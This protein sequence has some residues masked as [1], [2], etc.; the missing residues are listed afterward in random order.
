[1][2]NWIVAFFK[3]SDNIVLN[4]QSLDGFLLLRYLKVSVVL[5]GFGVLITWPILMPVNVTGG[6][7]QSQL[8]SLSF[9]NIAN[10]KDRYYAHVLV[11]WIFFALVF[12][13]VMR[14]S[15]YY[16][17]IRHAYL[18]SPMYANRVSS[19]TVLFTSVP[20]DYRNENVLRRVLGSQVKNI[21][22]AKD[23]AEIE[24]LVEER[25]RMAM[26]L[27]AAET[28]LIK[29]ANNARLKAAKS[30][31]HE[32]TMTRSDDVGADES[33]SLAA[34]WVQPGQR[35]SHRLR[36]LIG[37]KVDTI[38]WCRAEL[39]HM[40]PRVEAVQERFRSGE[41]K[42]VCSVFA[43]FY[44]QTEAQAAYQSLIH[45]QPLQ[46]ASRFIGV[47]P[48]EVIW[49]N[50]K[51]SGAS[52][53]VRNIVITGIVTALL[54]FWAI[55]VSFVGALSNISALTTGDP[56]AIPPVKP[57][58]PWLA[59]INDIPDLLLGVIQGFLPSALLALLMMLLPPFI[60]W[61]ARLSGQ[62]SLASVE[63]YVQNIYF[64]FQVIQ[65][66]LVTTITSGAAASITAIINNPTSATGLLAQDLPQA[67]NFYISYFV[68][69]GL[70]I[71]SAALANV[72][73]ILYF[74]VV[75]RL[76]DS[77]PRKMYKR[78]TELSGLGWGTEFPVYTL[79]TVIGKSLNM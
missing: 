46:M 73:G 8:N 44:S 58:L 69:Q 79:L 53:V 25:D 18:I 27:E 61:M 24:K 70:A 51:I 47:N 40:I 20:Q 2:F 32:D 76:F 19:R 26:M 34:R 56:T 39:E 21:W 60:R 3:M 55:P 28:K 30:G 64:L 42:A 52:R 75:S 5:C 31:K 71:A 62:P 66:F 9:G 50:L 38:N 4:R 57:L 7:Q 41:E 43:E 36:F 45:H 10:S 16:I 72:F 23:C 17:N 77:T 37:R 29:I 14:E 12:Y 33:G 74:M 6:G 11:A 48:E 13:M 78:F 1:M 49:E 67:S 65:V 54:I 68:L 35:P 22:I 63:L 15:I 59:W